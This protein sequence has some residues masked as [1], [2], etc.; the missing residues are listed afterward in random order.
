MA[1]H[2]WKPIL[3]SKFGTTM[4][5]KCKNCGFSI[6]HPAMED[7]DPEMFVYDM[8]GKQHTCD[9]AICLRILTE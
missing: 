7:P 8:L 5:W 2:D 3:S 6:V 1:D 4:T 9:E